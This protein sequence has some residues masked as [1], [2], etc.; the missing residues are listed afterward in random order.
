MLVQRIK[1]CSDALNSALSR[2]KDLEMAQEDEKYIC[3]VDSAFD[4][5]KRLLDHCAA[6]KYVLGWLPKGKEWKG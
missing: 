6:K 4:E 1:L 3:L 2:K 5:F